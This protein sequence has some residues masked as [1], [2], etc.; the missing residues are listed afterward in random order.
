M[1]ARSR[2]TSNYR[3]RDRGATRIDRGN[4]KV[5]LLSVRDACFF[6]EVNFAPN[7]SL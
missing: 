6:W 4:T 3:C 5:Y 1:G 2:A 7:V